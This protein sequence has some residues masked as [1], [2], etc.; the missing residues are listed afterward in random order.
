MNRLKSVSMQDIADAVGVSRAT[1]SNAL[2]GKG[3]LS[4]ETRELIFA[5]AERM[6]FTPSNLGRALRTGRSNAIGLVL[7]DF[8]MPL[9]A[10]FARAFAITAQAREMVLSV[11]DSMGS[12]EQQAAHMAEFYRR[13][14]DAI[15]IIP[16]RGTPVES[17]PVGQNILVIDSALNP[18]NSISSDHFMGGKLMAEHLIAEG[19]RDIILL[20]SHKPGEASGASLVNDIRRQGFEAGFAQADVNVTRL[21]LSSN[22]DH[23]RDFFQ[24]FDLGKNTALAATYDALALGAMHAFVARGMLIPQDVAITGFDDT[25]WGQ[26]IHPPLTTIRQDLA[27]LAESAFAIAL[28]ELESGLILPVE[29]VKRASSSP[30]E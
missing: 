16:V 28:G 21:S 18:R 23:A 4:D 3:R 11:A 15:V 20:D 9:F 10:E 1:V 26:I 6:N 24:D 30:Q 25:V 29:L 14:V 8:R 7:P 13:G 27:G 2:R 12:H 19:H 22:F 17:L 5:T